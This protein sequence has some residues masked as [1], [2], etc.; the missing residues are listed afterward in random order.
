[1]ILLTK[2]NIG[3]GD[4][5]GG[6]E[7]AADGAGDAGGGNETAA[8]DAGDAGGG[9]ATAADG[10]GDA[11]G[12]GGGGGHGRVVLFFLETFF[13]DRPSISLGELLSLSDMGN[14]FLYKTAY[15]TNSD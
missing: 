15:M 7:T 8:D 2:N 1:V 4:A 14:F 9:N 6:N 12:I 3:A 13:L 5:G 11:G 10:A